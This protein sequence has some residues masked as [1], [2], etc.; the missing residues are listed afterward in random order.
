MRLLTLVTLLA[1]AAALGTAAPSS[2]LLP[3]RATAVDLI[4]HKVVDGTVIAATAGGSAS[5]ARTAVGSAHPLQTVAG[6][7]GPSTILKGRAV[8]ICGSGGDALGGRRVGVRCDA[9]SLAEGA[10]L[11]RN[12]GQPAAAK[13]AGGA[14]HSGLFVVTAAALR[15][16]SSPSS[17]VFSEFSAALEGNANTVILMGGQ[18]HDLHD[19]DGQQPSPA[20]AFLASLADAL[21][22]RRFASAVYVTD[23]ASNSALLRLL[24]GS[25]GKGEEGI[26]SPPPSYVYLR[27]PAAITADAAHPQNTFP[28]QPPSTAL[29]PPEAFSNSYV[30]IHNKQQKKKTAEAA[31][32]STKKG[33][34][35]NKAA[36][37]EAADAALPSGVLIATSFD[38]IGAVP[39]A[40]RDGL[41]G[42]ASPAAAVVGAALHRV[43]ATLSG[44]A[45]SS[46]EGATHTPTAVYGLIGHSGG[47]GD[48]HL[49]AAGADGTL[50]SSA[51]SFLAAAAIIID[52]DLLAEESSAGSSADEAASATTTFF[53]QIAEDY[54]AANN[55]NG[56]NTDKKSMSAMVKAIVD[57]GRRSGITFTPEVVAK[58]TKTARSGVSSSIGAA[59]GVHQHSAALGGVPV[60][61]VTSVS[62]TA[63]QQPLLLRGR[64]AKATSNNNDASA[65]VALLAKVAASIADAATSYHAAA[66]TSAAAV[67]ESSSSV[68][69][70]SSSE[71]VL[72]QLLAASARCDRSTAAAIGLARHF[73]GGKDGAV[74]TTTGASLASAPEEECCV[75]GRVVEELFTSTIPSAAR[76][77]LPVTAASPLS[78][79]TNSTPAVV[80]LSTPSAFAAAAVTASSSTTSTSSA[81]S[82]AAL[83]LSG[84]MAVAAEAHILLES[85]YEAALTAAIVAYLVVLA[86]AMFGP[87]GAKRLLF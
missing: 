13:A 44:S 34:K 29:L 25:E 77:G 18:H 86:V 37:E 71:L 79:P 65:V 53:L 7:T 9:D 24:G 12:F 61:R 36:A 80:L 43:A 87:R 28:L 41:R 42:Y 39:T 67:P 51:G 45:A 74:T 19:V 59:G 81:V 60:I 8:V 4:L 20:S 14:T 5:A 63:P 70:G 85:S 11:M 48:L 75:F 47:L 66:S 58:P 52:T 2:P 33:R 31:G 32:T 55:A 76:R 17:S 27:R 22:T 6:A 1:S 46:G 54:A 10:A 26:A 30:V 72:G 49:A 57:A 62:A 38:T 23:S 68:S 50:S 84:P 40:A 69:S 21:A 73:G 3:L 83:L 82:A 15:E 16:A 35:N 78:A 56:S 64:G